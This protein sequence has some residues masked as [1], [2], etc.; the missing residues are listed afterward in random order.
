MLG[1]YYGVPTVALRYFNVYGPRQ[2]LS[3]P[4]TGVCAIFSSRIKND[5]PPIIYEDGLQSRD[6][7]S[8]HD[9]VRANILAM[10]KKEAD[11][12]AFNIGTGIATSILDIATVLS[13]LYQREITPLV[14]KKYRA[15]DIRHCIADITK[16]RTVLGYEPEISFDHGMRELVLWGKKVEAVD[17]VEMAIEE[18]KKR[19]LSD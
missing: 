16:A 11:H 6:F 13:S 12:Q 18:L 14:E 1:K 17:R 8:V 4:Y 9:V 10:Q 7:V 2:S 19:G 5:N 15:G 3:N